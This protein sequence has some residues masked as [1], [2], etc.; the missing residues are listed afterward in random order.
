MLDEYWA[1]T[2]ADR[3]FYDTPARLALG[4]RFAA[5]DRAVPSGWRRRERD[6]WVVLDP[7]ATALPHQGWKVHVSATPDDGERV[8]DTVWDFCLRHRISFK[9]LPTPR[10]LRLINGK[11]ANRA[12]SGKFVAIYPTTEAEL[13]TVLTGLDAE[14]AGTP[15]ARVLSDLRWKDG[16]LHVRYGGFTRMLLTNAAGNRVPALLDPDGTLVPDRRTPVFHT[17]P[18]VP[19]PDFLARAESRSDF[20]Y[21][22][23]SALHFSNAG[24][25]YRATRLADGAEV[26]LKEARPHAGLDRAGRDA[27]TRLNHEYAVL[28]ALDGITGV[29]RA[30][31]LVTAGGH[32][33]LVMDPAPGEVIWTWVARNHP[34]VTADPTADDLAAFTD[35]AQALGDRLAALLDEI[36]ARGVVYGDLH[37]GN[38]LITEDE[39]ISLVDFEVAGSATDPDFEPALG[40][41]G[42]RTA[43]LGR[44]GT[45]L[46]RSAL[47]ALRLWL[48]Q[49]QDRIWELDPAKVDAA[50][51]EVARRYPL[52][53]GLAEQWR[54]DL[55]PDA[56]S[57]VSALAADGKPLE[58][59]LATADLDAACR[60][61]A[62]AITASA[63]PDRTDRLF[64]GDIAAFRS[65]GADF[66]HGAAGVL[67]ARSI[68]GVG[69]DPAHLDWLLRAVSDPVALPPGFCTGLHG[70]AYVLAHLGRDDDAV[71][72]VETAAPMV[73]AVQA[74]TL[75][76]GLAG[77]ALNL[78]RLSHLDPRWADE[79]E[80]IGKRLLDTR[81]PTQAG[82]C[83]GWSGTAL[84]LLRLYEH[85]GADHWLDAAVA[86]LHRDLDTCV[87]RPDGTM[88]AGER[89]GRALPYLASGTAG[90][91]LVAAEVLRHR[92]DERITASMPAIM[93]VF[94]PEF[95]V[96]SN[97]FEGRAGLLATAARLR[98]P[99][100]AVDTHVR[101]LGWDALSYRG[102]L[103]FPGRRQ[104]RLSMDLATGGAGVLLALATARDPDLAFLPFLTTAPDPAR[105]TTE[106]G[107]EVS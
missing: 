95:V 81:P 40:A 63:T 21:R 87:I 67:W 37:P 19:V 44:R 64:P 1:Y 31:D 55:A 88:L 96:E 15:H 107:E 60:S 103:A 100:R 33:F 77:I 80:L 78:L 89:T 61:I 26:V 43:R 94:R 48:F 97:L 70:I 72:L 5:A 34:L 53:P 76:Q 39:R 36:H 25:V 47:A 75:Y 102:H 69:N 56:G 54:R 68:T 98:A 29:P 35:R 99:R 49:A 3:V 45:D 85:T 79:A 28:R 18:W 41:S 86:A 101:N 27:V 23:D 83:H 52:R 17:P 7:D 6:V 16:P 58:V 20:P 62:A 74:P 50:I 65:A 10:L 8:L 13:H 24:G 57:S 14:L 38:V 82:L 66:A 51:T 73:T 22:V 42:F 106:T 93:A 12:A 71:R 90:V 4:E 30:H 9:F 11:Y 105:A 91:G 92:A 46:D 2:F 59:D 104:F 84:A 32:S